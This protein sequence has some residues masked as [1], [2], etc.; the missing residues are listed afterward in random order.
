M[1]GVINE[2]VKGKE[3]EGRKKG[4]RRMVSYCVVDN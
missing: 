4:G 2:T 1:L 3:E